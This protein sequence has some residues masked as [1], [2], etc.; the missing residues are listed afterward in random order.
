[1]VT[2]PRRC[3]VKTMTSPTAKT[4]APPARLD[5]L[6]APAAGER[7]DV[8]HRLESLVHDLSNV[9]TPLLVLS[10]YLEQE[11][12]VADPLRPRL[13]EISSA[14]QR[15]QSI[16][17]RAVSQLRVE[18]ALTPRIDAS[19]LLLALRRTL[20]ITCGSRIQLNLLETPPGALVVL[21]PYRL[22]SA[23]IDLVANARDAIGHTGT[24]TIRVATSEIGDAL[25]QACRLLPG[26]YVVIE[27]SD[28]GVGIPLALR[29]RVFDR[30][31]TTKTTG[32]GLGLWN[33]RGFVEAYD[34]TIS[35]SSVEGRGTT[36]MLYF[37]RSV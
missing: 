9:L 19:A 13:S 10:D 36:F 7:S 21:D 6:P 20:E 28:T 11:L 34:G 22:E 2:S 29:D 31:F 15:A 33:V 37:P 1:M 35:V 3:D 18:R 16:V 23:L 27:V 30:F 17:Q 12:P 14:A 4:T 32:T 24:I 8:Q 25:A 5:T 26:P